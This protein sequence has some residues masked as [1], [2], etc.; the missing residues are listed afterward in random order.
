MQAVYFYILQQVHLSAYS[1]AL[2]TAIKTKTKAIT[3]HLFELRFYL[4]NVLKT[5]C[6]GNIQNET[7][8]T[9]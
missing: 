7:A 2:Q 8:I 4:L 6:L 5:N 1:L 3:E 9:C